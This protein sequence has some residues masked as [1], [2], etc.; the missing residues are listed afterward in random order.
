MFLLWHINGM[1]FD[2][3][4]LR[5]WNKYDMHHF[6]T[7]SSLLGMAGGRCALHGTM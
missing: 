6:L 5:A 1:I 2:L 4:T 3:H 7:S